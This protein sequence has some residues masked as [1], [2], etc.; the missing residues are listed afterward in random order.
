[1]SFCVPSRGAVRNTAVW[2]RRALSGWLLLPEGLLC[3]KAQPGQTC[4]NPITDCCLDCTKHCHGQ[5]LRWAKG[6]DYK[7]PLCS[8]A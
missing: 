4:A 5:N 6:C 7:K 1:M 3:D 2:W 8:Q